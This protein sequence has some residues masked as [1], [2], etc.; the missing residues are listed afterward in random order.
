MVRD[1][2]AADRVVAAAEVEE[3]SAEAWNELA[4]AEDEATET[5]AAAST[6]KSTKK[7]RAKTAAKPPAAP[8]KKEK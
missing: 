6:T 7:T 1:Q 5:A 8:K 4:A 3:I 2:K